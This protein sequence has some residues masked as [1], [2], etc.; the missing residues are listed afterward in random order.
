MLGKCTKLFI[1]NILSL[2][3]VFSLAPGFAETK[4]PRWVTVGGK[5]HHP[6]KIPIE[7]M[8]TNPKK[9]GRYDYTFNNESFVLFEGAIG[10]EY[11]SSLLWEYTKI[12]NTDRV[13]EIGTA[14]GA[15][16]INAAR[17]AKSVV[18]TDI[19]PVAIENAKFNARNKNVLSS[20]DFRVGDL[21][22]PIQ[23][24]EKF[25]VVLF[26]IVYPYTEK[27][28]HYWKLHERFLSQIG[29]HLNKN[30]RIYYIAGYWENIPHIRKM[31]SE[32]GLEIKQMHMWYMPKYYREPMVFELQKAPKNKRFRK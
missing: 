19:V 31:V 16:A 29:K 2:I 14:S 3:L 11:H 9:P 23:D 21:L 22:E 28:L 8:G 25:D 6:G 15:L 30:G 32:N 20:I 24:N 27:T 17:I 1:V 5:I 12:R 26:N 4:A 18:A 13:L 10:P 7:Y